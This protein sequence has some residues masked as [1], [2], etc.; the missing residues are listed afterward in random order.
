LYKDSHFLNESISRAT[1]SDFK[2]WNSIY[3]LLKLLRHHGERVMVAQQQQTPLERKRKHRAV[4][5]K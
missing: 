2:C 4:L 1:A 3:S 5:W